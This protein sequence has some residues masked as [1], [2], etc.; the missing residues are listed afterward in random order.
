MSEISILT[1]LGQSDSFLED[2]QLSDKSSSGW[3]LLGAWLTAEILICFKNYFR[4]EGTKAF[5]K[6]KVTNSEPYRR[7]LIAASLAAF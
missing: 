1:L 5:S 2:L 3:L 6:F 4:S 7:I